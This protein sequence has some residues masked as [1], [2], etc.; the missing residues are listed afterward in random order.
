MEA[1]PCLRMAMM[2]DGTNALQKSTKANSEQVNITEE[3]MTGSLL[4]VIKTCNI[5]QS[6]E[7]KISLD[8]STNT[9]LSIRGI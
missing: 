6:L 3:N 4:S 2:K 7:K 1:K 8:Y 9:S 5:S